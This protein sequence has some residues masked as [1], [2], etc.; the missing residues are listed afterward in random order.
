MKDDEEQCRTKEE[1]IRDNYEGDP[2]EAS[3]PQNVLEYVQEHPMTP[4]PIT[5]HDV[6][7]YGEA[8][9]PKGS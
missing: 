7:K 8:P 6:E 4:I 9:T 1:G 2:Y 5:E 3:T